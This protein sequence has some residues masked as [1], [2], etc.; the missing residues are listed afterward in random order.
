MLPTL[1]IG[2]FVLQTPGLA[3]LAGVYLA[4]ALIEKDAAR[5]KL[6]KEHVYNMVF[7]GLVIGVVGA[8]LAYAAR[9]FSV[10]LQTPLS[11]FA[12]N[13][14]TLS[15]VDGALIGLLAAMVYGWR[16]ALPLRPTLDALTAGLAAFMI[17]MGLAHLLSGDAFGAP[18]R[19]PWGI[20]L[21][22]EV[23]HPTQVYEIILAVAIFV[24]VRRWP[25]GHKGNGLNFLLFVALSAAARLFLE[26]F[27]GD[28][29]IWGDGWRAAQVISLGI[30]MAALWLMGRWRNP[31][32][33][34]E[35]H[36][37]N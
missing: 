14:Q 32:P 36:Y 37:E 16:K 12:L 4:M 27:R 29:L 28:S 13:P 3:L 10:Y 31:S 22:G 18:T 1:S 23:R 5:L 11:L 34:S 7:W 20:E 25:M 6:N 17:A 33:S 19:L 26:A 24:A 35:S 9:Y 21:W 15:P 2:S 8:R 30:L